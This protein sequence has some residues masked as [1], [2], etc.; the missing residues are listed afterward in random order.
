M[1]LSQTKLASTMSDA[2]LRQVE[3]LGQIREVAA[4]EALFD[5]RADSSI[6]LHVVVRGEL[7]VRLQNGREVWLGPGDIVG[8]IGFILGTPRTAEVRAGPSGAAVWRVARAAYLDRPPPERLAL[9]ARFFL[10]LA[11]LIHVRYAKVI[12]ERTAATGDVAR[13]HCDDRHPAIRH[14]A[15]FL[16]GR[17]PWETTR[18]VFSFVRQIPYRIGFWQ[19]KASRTLELGF[20][21]CTTKSNLQVALLRASGIDAEFGEVRCEAGSM[22]AIL[23]AG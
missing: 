4:G 22:D 7:A 23:P 21:M 6:D 15:A 14:M 19:V 2:L 16:A 17:D 11:P 12:A 18:A 5:A 1:S 3:T 20:G 10:G 8:E 9:L 13:D